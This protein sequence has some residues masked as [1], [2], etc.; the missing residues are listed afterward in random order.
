[1]ISELRY[2]PWRQR[3]RAT[4]IRDNTTTPRTSASCTTTH[5]GTATFTVRNTTGLESLT[6]YYIPGTNYNN[7]TVVDFVEAFPNLPPKY[8]GQS[9]SLWGKYAPSGL[10]NN[11]ST[12]SGR[13]IFQIYI[14][15]EEFTLP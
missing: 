4:R 5:A 7:P 2:K 15:T 9:D 3:P 11:T 13:A 14:W 6:H 12:G 8:P 1:M 10:I